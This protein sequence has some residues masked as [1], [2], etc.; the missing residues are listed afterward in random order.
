[1]AKAKELTFEE[2]VYLGALR[3]ALEEVKGKFDCAVSTA[4]NSLYTEATGRRDGVK[5]SQSLEE[6][7]LIVH[8]PMRGFVLLHPAETVCAR[9]V[10]VKTS[11]K[12]KSELAEQLAKLGGA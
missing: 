1:M 7:G 12:A 9:C 8:H 5:I 10:K 3:K 6:K 11:R 2:K 4:V